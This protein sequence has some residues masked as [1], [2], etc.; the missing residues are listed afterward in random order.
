MFSGRLVP[1]SGQGGLAKIQRVGLFTPA[2]FFT[3]TKSRR[4]RPSDT[5]VKQRRSNVVS[6]HHLQET[7]AP[8]GLFA[9]G[10]SRLLM[11]GMCTATKSEAMR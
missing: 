1:A 5:H 11:V 4:L 10:F 6:K 3:C 7:A 2:T 9:G 8:R